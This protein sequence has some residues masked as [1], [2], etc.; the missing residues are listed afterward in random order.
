MCSSDLLEAMGCGVPSIVSDFSAQP[1]I[2][3]DTG[4]KV[5]GQ[6]DWDHNQAAWF[7]TPSTAG[8]VDALEEAYQ[9]RGTRRQAC[10]ERAELYRADRVYAEHWRPL[11]AS[12]E[13]KPERKGM[14][15]AARRRAKKEGQR[16]A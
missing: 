16:A 1:E 13:P 4:W 3:G 12:L 9:Q 8:I 2:V 7:F 11:L 14:S 6:L 15:N 10:I 5:P